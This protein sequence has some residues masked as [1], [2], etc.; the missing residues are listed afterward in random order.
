[1]KHL[2]LK[3]AFTLL[4]VTQPFSAHAVRWF[5]VEMIAFEQ[6]PASMLRE[7]FTL[8]HPDIEGKNQ[9]DLLTSGFNAQGQQRCLEGD[10]DFDPRAL[11]DKLDGSYSWSCPDSYDYISR[12]ET[13]PI[14]PYAQSQEHMDNIYLLSEQQL[15]FSNILKK[16][17]RKGQKPI[18]HT[19]WRFPEQSQRRAPFIKIYG[20]KRFKSPVSYKLV[21]TVHQDGYSGLLNPSFELHKEG[22]KDNWQLEGLLKIHVRHYLYVTSN[23][24]V[25]Y[26]LE[27]GAIEKARMSQFTRVYS[28][29]IHYL[30]HP[31]LGIIFQI[32]KYQ[33]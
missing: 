32:R 16:L 23:I 15:Q 17:Q 24:D 19:G 18:L 5:E 22:G 6:Q 8:V 33:H 10:S 3:S 31:K 27:D 14:S 4:L 13:L 21:D 29:D 28:G 20:G 25:R 9:R 2:I 30:D 12:Y 7:D 11:I 1:M 26:Q